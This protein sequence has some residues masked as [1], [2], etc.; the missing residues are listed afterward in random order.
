MMTSNADFEKPTLRIFFLFSYLYLLCTFAL[1][2]HSPSMC[3]RLKALRTE[4]SGGAWVN[5][6]DPE[7]LWNPSDIPFYIDHSL[8]ILYIRD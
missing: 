3:L 8:G 5:Y 4:N 7:L 6:S 1:L 2:S